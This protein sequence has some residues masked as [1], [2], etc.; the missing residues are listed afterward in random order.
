MQKVE[1]KISTSLEE[2]EGVSLVGLALNTLHKPTLG[3]KSYL[4]KAQ[5]QVALDIKEGK[6]DTI[7]R[8]IRVSA[9]GRGA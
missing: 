4:S 7:K 2:E 1:I 9:Q 6:H 5:V 8:V 3:R